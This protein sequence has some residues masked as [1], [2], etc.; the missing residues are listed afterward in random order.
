MVISAEDMARFG[1]LTLNRGRWN[2]KQLL[3]ED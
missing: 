1:L 3:S 2:G